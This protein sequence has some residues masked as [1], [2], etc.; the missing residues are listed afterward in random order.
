MSRGGEGGKPAYLCVPDRT[1]HALP[2]NSRLCACEGPSVRRC[3]SRF[4][5]LRQFRRRGKM[6]ILLRWKFGVIFKFPHSPESSRMQFV[7]SDTILFQ[8]THGPEIDGRFWTRAIC[9]ARGFRNLLVVCYAEIC[10]AIK[11]RRELLAK[12]A[13]D[14]FPYWN[15]SFDTARRLVFVKTSNL[16]NL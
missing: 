6:F 9:F 8:G 1:S 16:I 4:P 10:T 3:A 14:W 15:F 5:N 11:S 2:I 13:E 7:P 12:S